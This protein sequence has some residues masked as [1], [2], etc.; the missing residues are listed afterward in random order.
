[1]RKIISLLVLFSFTLSACSADKLELHFMDVG[2]G[3]S[4][5]VI[6]PNGNSIL[7]DAGGTLGPNSAEGNVREYILNHINRDQRKINTLI[8]T[9]PDE[10]HYNFL[11][12]VLRGVGVDK[13]FRVGVRNDY[14]EL[15]RNWLSDFP[16]K[17]VIV[18]NQDYFNPK[19]TPNSLIDCGDA[20]IFILAA[21]IN[22]VK[23]RKKEKNAMSIVV[24]IRYG[25]VE[26]ILLGDATHITENMI[27]NRYQNNWLDI[28]ILKVG[29][30]GS[31]T[32]ST[33]KKW[34][35]TTKPEIAIVSAGINNTYGHPRGVVIKR[36]EPH[37]QR[38]EPHPMRYAFVTSR[39]GKYKWKNLDNYRESIYS[40]ATNGYIVIKT[41]G[42]EIDIKT[43]D[44]EESEE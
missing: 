28:E 40:T 30:H 15:F 35:D 19:E 7:I 24:M 23:S 34:A 1:M 9:H 12:K 14:N 11:P 27:L 38:V 37:T 10:D 42:N 8:I 16:T 20:D 29:H 39:R 25:N 32:T 26:A 5:L 41:D 44:F 18:L 13:V 17:K 36:L 31:S 3:D 33:S 21:S 6:C 2:Q 4:T 43:F 22:A